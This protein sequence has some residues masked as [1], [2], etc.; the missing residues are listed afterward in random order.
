[1]LLLE[2]IEM[3]VSAGLSLPS[4]LT[5]IIP[6][7]P[8]RQHSSLEALRTGIE[9]GHLLSRGF[10]EHIQLS[11]SLIGL[12]EQG[13]YTG[14]LPRSLHLCR[15]IIERE[16]AL[17]KTCTSAMAYPVV[18]A[19]FSIV[20][21]IGLMQGVMPQI[22]PLLKSLHVALPL[23]TRVVLYVSEHFIRYGAYIFGVGFI[24][25]CSYYCT[26][27]YVSGKRCATAYY[28]SSPS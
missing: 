21:T 27:K 25:V 19:L 4:A 15:T 8:V 26:I 3:Y 5:A 7:F 28:C 13:E 1:M 20:L 22:I 9:Q 2:N 10:A 24:S 12:I 6:A 14:G 17:I 11:P 23:V 18:I 16:D